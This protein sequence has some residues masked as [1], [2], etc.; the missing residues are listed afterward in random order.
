M[1][2]IVQDT[3][4]AQ[5]TEIFP[6]PL[7]PRYKDITPFVEMDNTNATDITY[8]R[9]AIR[10]KK[11]EFTDIPATVTHAS[12]YRLIAEILTTE[13]RAL[14]ASGDRGLLA[15]M[16]Q[17]LL[18]WPN[19]PTAQIEIVHPRLGI[20]FLSFP[21]L[22]EEWIYPKEQWLLEQLHQFKAEG[23]R[24]I[25]YVAHVGKIDVSARLKA[26]LERPYNGQTLK[27][28]VL[29]SSTVDT[30]DRMDWIEETVEEGVDVL[31][32][33][34]QLV[35]T[36]LDL[37]QF[38]RVVVYQMIY[39]SYTLGQCVRRVLR[40]GQQ[41]DVQVYYTLYRAAMEVAAAQL[42]AKKAKAN[43]QIQGRDLREAFI[44]QYA[45]AD[46]I[47]DILMR[48]IQSGLSTIEISQEE[49]QSL[50]TDAQNN[51]YRAENEDIKNFRERFGMDDPEEWTMDD[52][53]NLF[54]GLDDDAILGMFDAATENI[55]EQNPLT[56][57]A[58][59]TPL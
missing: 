18:R 55:I 4:F 29:R 56:I 53:D 34:P 27:V 7:I 33:N 25:V 2:Y 16:L 12:A 43:A 41:H 39:N 13:A 21:G 58:Q 31:L 11:M 38:S 47:Q 5:L 40:V 30:A 19:A 22:P 3:V 14:L 54:D 15:I 8:R 36:G 23:H 26:V 35:E 32:C 24:T 42:M 52:L 1:R 46:D 48:Q 6:W 17:T 45:G 57:D 10:N 37:I 20:P 59:V 49:I 44:T 50:F 9:Y 51:R 28:A